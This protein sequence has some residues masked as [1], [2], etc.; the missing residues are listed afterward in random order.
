M[1]KVSAD[2]Q[3]LLH[4]GQEQAGKSQY[5]RSFS[6]ARNKM[7]SQ[8]KMT[9]LHQK[10]VDSIKQRSDKVDICRAPTIKAQYMYVLLNF[11]VSDQDEFFVRV[12]QTEL[13]FHYLK[14]RFL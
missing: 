5:S 4:H 11:V 2:G 9:T 7:M 14:N 10:V 1:I 3:R 6:S 8:A 13:L 12:T